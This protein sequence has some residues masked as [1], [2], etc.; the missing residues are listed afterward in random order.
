MSIVTG[1]HRREMVELRADMTAGHLRPG[2]GRT[3]SITAAE[4]QRLGFYG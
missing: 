3:R 2:E 1:R 4:P